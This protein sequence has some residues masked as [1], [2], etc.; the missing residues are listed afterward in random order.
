[1]SAPPLPLM[2]LCNAFQHMLVILVLGFTAANSILRPALLPLLLLLTLYTLPLNGAI[3]HPVVHGLVNFNT[4]GV[5]FQYLD[6]ACISR[7]S[8]SAGG[9]TS[10]AGGHRN[11]RSE[12]K[13]DTSKSTNGA[14]EVLGRLRF[15]TSL[16]TTWRGAGTAWEVKYTPR[17]GRAPS[18]ARFLVESALYLTFELLIL[19]L[20]S[21]AKGGTLEENAVTFSWDRVRLLS[22]LPEMSR[23]EV[24]CRLKTFLEFWVGT[25]FAMR[26]MH[27]ILAI[28]GVVTGL[29]DVHRWPPLFGPISQ[30]YTMRR[31]WGV[32]WHQTLRQKSGSPAYY[33]T[34]SILGL[35]KG[36]TVTRYVH[37]FLTFIVSAII[38]LLAE[39]YP[40]GIDWDRSGTTR[41]FVTQAF[42]ILL[43]DLVQSNLGPREPRWWTKAVGWVWVALFT[44]WSSPSHFYP[45]LQVLDRSNGGVPPV[46]VL[47]PLI[48]HLSARSVA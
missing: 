25:Y 43:E 39:E 34:Y 19:D 6:C 31:F 42:G 18:R 5:F 15:G 9:P 40:W 44:F 47:R 7:W 20:L 12:P 17:F 14:E 33:T 37:L 10:G 4:V 41:F 3:P 22:R 16:V 26:A 24:I 8:Y 27:H 45:R 48:D 2:L 1:M 35:R 13:H 28:V 29:K 38:H 23:D 32:F 36:G 21:L 46:S 30:T 11:L